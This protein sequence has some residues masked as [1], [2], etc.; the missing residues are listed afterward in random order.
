[1]RRIAAITWRNRKTI[2][3]HSGGNTRRIYLTRKI[4][5]VLKPA[6]TVEITIEDVD[7]SISKFF[8]L[9]GR[10]VEKLKLIGS[11]SFFREFRFYWINC[12]LLSKIIT[13]SDVVIADHIRSV[14]MLAKCNIKKPSIVI[15]H[16]YHEE[17]PYY[18]V[19]TKILRRILYDKLIYNYLNNYAKIIITASVRD[20]ILYSEKIDDHT[21]IIPY[22]NLYYPDMKLKINKRSDKLR[23]FLVKLNINNVKDII[24][25]LLKHLDNIEIYSINMP[26]I[27]GVHDLGAIS[28]R[29]EYLNTLANGHI[30][31][32][33]NRAKYQPGSNV[34]RYDY[35]IAGNVPFNYMIN[36]VGEPLPHEF[37]FTDKYDLVAKIKSLSIEEIIK[38]GIE[39]AE[40]VYNKSI[41]YN[42]ILI[43]TIQKFLN[44]E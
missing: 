28:S 13:N 11:S 22:P 7:S 27:P 25:F 33:F 40:Y 42:N 23:I 32:N 14:I 19:Y 12:D 24:Y 17:F 20:K 37:T 30:G 43:T 26:K 2:N 10:I 9:N 41:E 36:A 15:L 16:D 29:E 31:I 39:N 34:K 4:Y 3:E 38:Y 6:E 21:K 35:A 18:H 5:E 44:F 1:M 8:A